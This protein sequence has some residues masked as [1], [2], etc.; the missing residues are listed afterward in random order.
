MQS[1]RESQAYNHRKKKAKKDGKEYKD[2]L[3]ELR[4]NNGSEKVIWPVAEE[5][6]NDEVKN[7]T[8]VMENKCL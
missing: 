6:W 4:S 7:Y 5:I 2:I 3:T 1:K 8:L